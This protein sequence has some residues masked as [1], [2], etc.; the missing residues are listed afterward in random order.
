MDGSVPGPDAYRAFLEGKVSV[1]QRHGFD[2]DPADLNPVLK[3]HQGAMAR[4]MVA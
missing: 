2:V 1:A 3:G 4:W